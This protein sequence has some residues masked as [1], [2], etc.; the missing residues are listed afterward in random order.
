M[1]TTWGI[2]WKAPFQILITNA[3]SW[4]STLSGSAGDEPLAEPPHRR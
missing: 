2:L 3:A 4:A 1:A